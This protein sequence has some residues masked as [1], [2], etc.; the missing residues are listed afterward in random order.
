MG[1][2]RLQLSV[3]RVI[4]ASLDAAQ[5]LRALSPEEVLLRREMKFE[6]LGL[7][8]LCR[9]IFQQR[10]RIR[11]L[12]EGDAN[13]KFFHLHACHRSRKNLIIS[14]VQDGQSFSDE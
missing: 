13:T 14:L 4:I 1:N 2:M 9:T 3:A 8:S 12:M 10:S 5:D 6:V 11:E 7:A